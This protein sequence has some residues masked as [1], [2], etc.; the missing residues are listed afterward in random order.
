MPKWL[1]FGLLLLAPTYWRLL[2]ALIGAPWGTAA[3]KPW[4]V[5]TLTVFLRS[6]VVVAL[7]LVYLL[8]DALLALDAVL[9]AL[10]R[11]FVTGRRL[12]EW[13][14]AAEASLSSKGATDLFLK[15]AP[16]LAAGITVLVATRRPEALVAAAPFLLA[17]MSARGLVRWLNRPPSRGIGSLD[18]GDVSFLREHSLRTWMFFAT[19]SA[20]WNHWLIPDSVA[21]DGQRTDRT[22]PTN[23]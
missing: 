14:T 18:A 23:L 15:W 8:H 11:M 10:A 21:A 4:S 6:H 5:A 13:E 7:H 12:L 2:F 3:F 9:R 1:K 22:S 16:L 20:Q 19:F 17:W